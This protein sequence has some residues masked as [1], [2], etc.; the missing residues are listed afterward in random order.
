MT[1]V[2]EQYQALEPV[3]CLLAH[4]QM[5]HIAIVVVVE[6]LCLFKYFVTYKLIF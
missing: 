2:S 3:S 4:C 5:L 1:L 6:A